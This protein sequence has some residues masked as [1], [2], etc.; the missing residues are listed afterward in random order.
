MKAKGS[1]VELQERIATLAGRS[2]RGLQELPP[3]L[4]HRRFFRVE[5]DDPDIPRTL[6]A[7]VEGRPPADGVL[8]A[9]P[10]F[11]PIR[12]FLAA[13]DLPVP[14][15][16][17][18][19]GEIQLLEDL[20]DHSLENLAAEADP[21]RCH[22]LY[23]EACSLIPRLQRLT[24]PESGGVAAFERRWD[25]P[26]VATKARKWLEWSF[27]L[28][29]GRSASPA[30]RD[31]ITEAFAFVARACEAAPRRLAHRDFK[32]ANLHLRSTADSSELVM[33]DLQGALLAP[34]E[35]DLVCL[36]R[37]AHVALS[38]AQVQ[39]HLAEFRPQLPDAPDERTF[40][41]RFDLITLVRV[42]KDLSHY[43]HA[44]SQRGDRRY[45]RLVPNALANLREA[46]V[47]ARPRDPEIG[48]LADV[49]E[50]APVDLD[51]FSSNGA[52]A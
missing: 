44:A 45:L 50:R 27:P 4:G 48:P 46:A 35:Y 25:R 12:A 15:S 33:I 21:A 13:A 36:L 20:G 14:H 29:E 32:A 6:V 42:A 17:A 26:L 38:E 3:G 8:A 23:T 2:P 1:T 34:P 19:D 40:L 31:A 47:R 49:I 10:E 7:R 28:I 37:D 5:F 52:A 22:A 11:E 43:L 16:Y 51:V 39:N 30:E 18:D 24:P 41:R 9:E